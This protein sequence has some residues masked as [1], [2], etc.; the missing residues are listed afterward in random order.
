MTKH[1]IEEKGES[2]RRD[3]ISH[4]HQKISAQV[5]DFVSSCSLFTMYGHT[6]VAS[7]TM[8]ASASQERGGKNSQDES[9]WD[10]LVA[11]CTD[12][13]TEEGECPS[14]DWQVILSMVMVMMS[15]GVSK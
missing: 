6:H 3:Q 2:D 7:G 9:G 10:P 8:T 13:M 11:P 15:G 12:S 14:T 4:D 5:Y 1:E